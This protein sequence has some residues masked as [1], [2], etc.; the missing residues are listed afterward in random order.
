[1]I[2]DKLY[3]KKWTRWIVLFLRLAVGSV[4]VFSG[5][6]KAIDPWGVL[7][8][9][10]DYVAALG[11]D[12]LS[13]FLLFGAFAVSIFEFV[14]GVCL[15]IGAYRRFSVWASFL[16]MIVMT[17]LT[18][19]LSITGAVSDCGCFGEAITLSNT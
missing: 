3:S 8:K 4:F 1:M 9:F 2:D 10:Q 5:F 12:W 16:L 11:W 17:P 15:I 13:P 19:W 6:V 18:L 7:Y 14:L